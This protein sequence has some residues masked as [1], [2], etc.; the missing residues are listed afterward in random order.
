MENKIKLKIDFCSRE[1]AKIAC[2]RW[3]YS[4]CL[5]GADLVCCGVWEEERFIGVIIFSRGATPE[6]GKPYKLLQ[7]EVCELTRIALTKHKSYVSKMIKHAIKLLKK[8]CPKC[9]LIVSF[10]DSTQGHYGGIYQAGNWL[11]L[12]ESKTHCFVV[13][14]K[15]IHP[16]SLHSKFGT[17]GQSVKWLRE[18]V[19]RKARR[20]Q[21]IIKYRYVMPLTDDLRRE[22]ESKALDYPSREGGAVPTSTLHF[23]EINNGE[24]L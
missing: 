24:K 5:P 2:E 12:G 9:K 16:K 8:R 11:Y 21:N 18:N 19:D 7:N 10:A 1:H 13:H 6:I 22:L 23:E 3:H 17:G 4:K 15:K 20:E 14:N